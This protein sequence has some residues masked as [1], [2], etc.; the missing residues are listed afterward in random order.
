MG[1]VMGEISL[2]IQLGDG[3]RRKL[4][5]RAIRRSP[6]QKMDLNH[7]IYYVAPVRRIQ[8]IFGLP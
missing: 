4:P 5:Q 3:K 7:E 6:G 8:L 2:S 1:S